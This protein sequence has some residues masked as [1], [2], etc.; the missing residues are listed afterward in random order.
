MQ[1]TR[2]FE[3]DLTELAYQI[4]RSEGRRHRAKSR[5]VAGKP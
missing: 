5:P 1:A 3:T 2:T 4:G